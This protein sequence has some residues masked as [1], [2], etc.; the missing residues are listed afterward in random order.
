MRTVGEFL[1]PNHGRI[2]LREQVYL[3]HYLVPT[4][5]TLWSGLR[6]SKG[7]GISYL[8]LPTVNPIRLIILTRISWRKALRSNILYI[9]PANVL[10][11]EWLKYWSDAVI[12]SSVV[13]K[14]GADSWS[15]VNF[16]TRRT[17]SSK[18]SIWPGRAW[19]FSKLITISYLH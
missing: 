3:Q 1:V 7:T 11:T 15:G 5:K 19:M 10:G 8:P 14:S 13:E 12:S 17:A 9:L 18:H 6:L 2:H 16:T 4:T